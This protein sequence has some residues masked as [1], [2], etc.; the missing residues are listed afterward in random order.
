MQPDLPALIREIETLRAANADLARRAEGLAMA[1]AHAAE[2]LAALEE[3]HER[4]QRL[5]ERGEELELQSHLDAILQQERD[6]ARLISRIVELIRQ[7]PSLDLP[8]LTAETLPSSNTEDDHLADA[9]R[10]FTVPVHYSGQT[11]ARLRF[12]VD[13]KDARWKRRWLP[14]LN[15]FGSQIGQAVLRLRVEQHNEE[16]QTDLVRAR[17]EALSANQAKSVF[18]ANMSHELRTPLNAIIGYSEMLIEE[19]SLGDA[20]AGDLRRILAAGRHLLNLI[21]D[22]LDLSKIEANRMT[23][24]LAPL[25]IREAIESA[26]ATVGPVLAQQHNQLVV[27]IPPDIDTLVSDDLKFRQILTNLLGNAAKFTHNG[28]VR[29]EASITQDTPAPR[30]VVAVSDTGIGMTEQQ[31]G[32]LFQPFAQAD[33]STTR[34]YGGT[35]LGLA[36]SRRLAQMLGGDVRVNSKPGVGSTFF[37]DLPFQSAASPIPLPDVP[38]PAPVHTSSAITV[39]A[40]D[41]S[42][43]ALDIIQRTLTKGGYRVL[44]AESGES[45]VALAREHLPHVITLDVVMPKLNGWQVLATL[46]ADPTLAQIP[47]VL[48]SVVE[49]RQIGLAL[50]A[51]D[52]L[53]KPIDWNRLN[54]TLSRL[55]PPSPSRS[56]LIVED[57]PDAQE[58]SRRILEKDGWNILV[59]SNGREALDVIARQRPALVILDLMMPV[60]D[61]FSL[62]DVMQ[63]DPELAS[64]PI[65]VLTSKT[66]S[67]E[68]HRRINGRVREI[69]AKGDHR[70]DL[71][72]AIHRLTALPPAHSAAREPAN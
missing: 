65:L 55:S 28:S 35:G 29:V 69:L 50:G 9:P 18:L 45:G 56:V 62:V 66:L 38:T 60:M 43:E 72:T 61:G 63:A 36:I 14:L 30:L 10:P 25:S 1:N 41:D 4:E 42:P 44:T 59:A 51:T 33:A 22:V 12:S 19:Q 16:I 39:L 17:D 37:L 27:R 5:V 3:A 53:S 64:I 20:A 15:S 40:I 11:F 31:I 68:D 49:N 2:L 71:L 52:C 21:N 8:L 23:V 67:P 57:D 34:K 7:V 48:I 46:K 54:T 26:A 47:V 32:R 6:E 24:S 70:S 58:L 13:N